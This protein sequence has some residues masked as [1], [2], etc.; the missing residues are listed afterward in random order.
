MAAHA[1]NMQ[2]HTL[3]VDLPFYRWLTGQPEPPRKFATALFCYYDGHS[4]K[5]AFN[6]D[7]ITNYKHIYNEFWRQHHT[8]KD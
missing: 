1:A 4:I 8:A 7:E 2:V 5:G 3:F 6:P